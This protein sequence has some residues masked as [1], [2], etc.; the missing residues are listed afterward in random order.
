MYFPFGPMPELQNVRRCF[1]GATTTSWSVLVAAILLASPVH[2]QHNIPLTLAEAEDKAL[3]AEPG[4]QAMYARA[5]ALRERGVAAGELPDPMLRVGLNNFP[6]QSGGFSTEGMTSAAVGL[7]QAFPA[8]QTRV[9]NTRRFDS[10]A[11][12]MNQNAPRKAL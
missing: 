8:S 10:L 1:F 4:Q 2:S 12:E 5:L 11:D 9:S 6:I 3:L 7:R